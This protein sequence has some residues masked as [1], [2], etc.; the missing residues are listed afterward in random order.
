MLIL[1]M[2]EQTMG[3]VCIVVRS[4]GELTLGMLEQVIGMC[5]TTYSLKGY[6]TDDTIETS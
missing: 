4:S 3:F 2:F 5:E 1:M 6:I